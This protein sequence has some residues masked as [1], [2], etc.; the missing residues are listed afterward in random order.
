[1]SVLIIGL[2]DELFGLFEI[3]NGLQAQ[4][5]IACS[6]MSDLCHIAREAFL[7]R[8]LLWIKFKVKNDVVGKDFRA[9]EIRALAECR[10]ILQGGLRD[11]IAKTHDEVLG[12]FV[13]LAYVA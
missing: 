6:V 13:Y 7:K 1:M 9:N 10:V 3:R 5:D 4:L 12:V 2:A 8:K 11:V